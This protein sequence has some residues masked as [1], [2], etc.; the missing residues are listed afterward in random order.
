MSVSGASASDHVDGRDSLRDGLGLAMG[1]EPFGKTPK[2]EPVHRIEISN[3]NLSAW[4]LTY[5]AAVQDLRLEGHP[6]PLVLGFPEL[7]S[8]FQHSLYFGAIVGRYANRIA[9]GKFVIEGERFQAD[10]NDNGNTLHGGRD[11]LDRQVWA[12]RSCGTDFVTL[13]VENISGTMGFPGTLSVTCTYR[14]TSSSALRVEIEATTDRT[15]LCNIASHCYFNLENG[16]A[17]DILDHRLQIAAQAYTPV[18]TF[19]IPTGAVLPVKDTRFDFFLPRTIRDVSGNGSYDHNFCLAAARGTFRQAA[20]VQ[21][22]R[23]GIEMEVWTTEPGVQL[24]TGDAEPP[25][26]Y[27]LDGVRYQRFSG[28]CLEPQVWPDSPNHPY[29]P[30]AI[31]RPE[32]RYRQHSEYRFHLPRDG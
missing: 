8:Y 5:G 17:G 3:G 11:G 1:R 26:A 21:S 7:E 10:T 31:L 25:S 22:E 20:W 13:S 12:V 6:F 27:G 24:F 19:N 2:G 28:F 23:S 9:G 4:I 32:E 18:N 16:G 30:Q 29:F 15:T 14:I